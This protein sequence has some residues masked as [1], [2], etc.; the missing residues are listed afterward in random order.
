[1]RSALRAVHERTSIKQNKQINKQKAMHTSIHRLKPARQNS[2]K[3]A[4]S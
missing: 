1:M 2:T 4:F 3:P